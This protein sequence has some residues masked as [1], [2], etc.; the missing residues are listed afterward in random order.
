MGGL[1]TLQNDQ[2]EGDPFVGGTPDVKRGV[3]KVDCYVKTSHTIQKEYRMLLFGDLFQIYGST[4]PVWSGD[5]PYE[6][7]VVNVMGTLAEIIVGG[8]VGNGKDDFL[9]QSV[10]GFG[11]GCRHG[12]LGMLLMDMVLT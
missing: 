12:R 8:K 5:D 9:L 3:A 1:K 2:F 4:S 7:S 10:V 6:S 11:V